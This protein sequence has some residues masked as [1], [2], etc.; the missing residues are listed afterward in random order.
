MVFSEVEPAQPNYVRFRLGPEVAIAIGARAK[1]SGEEMA[2]EDIELYVR[3][4]RGDEMDAYERLIGDAMKGD[5]TLFARED[6]VEA[7]WR[8]VDPILK[9]PTPIHIY[10][11]GTW[12]PSEADKMIARVGGWHSPQATM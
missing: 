5:S 4:Q 10:E 1:I 3:H 9:A 7:A 6:G 2:G 8:V 12:G 11:A